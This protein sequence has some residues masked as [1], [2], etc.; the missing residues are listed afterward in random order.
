MDSWAFSFV[1]GHDALHLASPPHSGVDR[2]PD[3]VER[4]TLLGH[5][6]CPVRFRK[7]DVAHGTVIT[8]EAGEQRIMTVVL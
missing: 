3:L 1:V 6:I 8:L 2:L 5:E 7:T 4:G